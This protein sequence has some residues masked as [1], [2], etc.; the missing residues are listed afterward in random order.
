MI[1]GLKWFLKTNVI[2][3]FVLLFVFSSLSGAYKQ[4]SNDSMTRDNVSSE[5]Y[6][7]ADSYTDDV[8]SVS[9]CSCDASASPRT[10][11]REDH[12]YSCG[13]P[14]LPNAENPCYVMNEFIIP[15]YDPG[16]TDIVIKRDLPSSFNWRTYN[17]YDW[18][19]PARDQGGCGSCWAFAAV[20]ALESKINIACNAPSLDLDLSEQY[21]LSCLPAS[22]SCNGGWPHSVYQEMLR[23]DGIITESCFPYRGR[24]DVPCTDKCSYW[25]SQLLQISGYGY[26]WYPNRDVYKTLLITKGPVSTAFYATEDFAYWGFTHHSPNDVYRTTQ[27][28]SSANHA[29]IIVGYNDTGGYWICKNSWG[30]YWGYNGFFNIGYGCLNID[31]LYVSW[32]DFTDVPVMLPQF[33]Y[34]ISYIYIYDNIQFNDMSIIGGSYISSWHWDFGDGSTSNEQN[35][36][37]MYRRRGVYPVTLTITSATGKTANITKNVIIYGPDPLS[38]VIYGPYAGIVNT[39]ITFNYGVSGGDQPYIINWDFGDGNTSDNNP[40]HT[41][42][43]DDV[44]QVTLTVTD[45]WGTTM[46]DTITINIIKEEDAPVYNINKLNYYASLQSAIDDADPG[47]TI[48]ARERVYNETIYINKPLIIIGENPETTII[49]KNYNDQ[50][51]VTVYSTYNVYISG[52]TVTGVSYG[53]YIYSSS[54]ITITNSIVRYAL[55]DG[56]TLS[57]SMYCTITNNIIEYNS[58]GLHLWDTDNCLIKENTIK[59]NNAYGVY[60]FGENNVI[61]HNRFIGN[62]QQAYADLINTWCNTL[63]HEGNY[64]SDYTGIDSNGDGIGDTPYVIPGGSSMDLYPLMHPFILG[65]V[66]GDWLVSFADIDYFVVALSGEEYFNQQ[67]QYGNYWAADCNQDDE[68]SFAD[69][70]R[71]VRLLA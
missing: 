26:Q 28:Y 10:E 31:S 56:L 21:V 32:V 42:T 30:S 27:H 58:N 38:V 59:N 68:V 61:Y 43:R 52:F 17:G 23:D 34:D 57:S 69:I 19:T 53:I 5:D 22:G 24:D 16:S 44:Y 35:P 13:V 45:R 20:G 60:I 55:Y 14:L 33:E 51:G 3:L 39:S 40:T 66:N 15:E 18:T 65:D 47:D 11:Y 2:T 49:N 9:L 62:N 8:P 67:Y 54:N 64:W 12:Q 41:Y 70:D 1:I 6:T 25:R 63:S 37:H 48:T 29:V 4:L 50:V 7:S 36:V 46:N 71:F